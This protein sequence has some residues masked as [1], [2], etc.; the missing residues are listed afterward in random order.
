MRKYTFINKGFTFERITKKQAL[1]AYKNGLTVLLCPVNMHPFS[2]WGAAYNL[3]RKSREQFVIDEI[4]LEKDFYSYIN[5]F[6]YYNCPN[7]E[8]G[9]YTAFYIPVKEVDRF[10]GE[11]PTP[12][13]MGTMKQYDYSYM[14]G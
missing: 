4:G 5:S 3:N 1:Q 8:T 9:K 11:T 7:T 6:E 10:T 12:E 14:E 2:P 13:T